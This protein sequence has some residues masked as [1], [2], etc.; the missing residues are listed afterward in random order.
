MG[1]RGAIP[2]HKHLIINEMSNV[3]CICNCTGGFDRPVAHQELNHESP[4]PS[5]AGDGPP[6]CGCIN[7]IHSPLSDIFLVYSER[8]SLASVSVQP[9][10]E[11]GL[12]LKVTK[13]QSF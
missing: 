11:R 8:R 9:V 10:L 7:L 5:A 1:E 2:I 4:H 12:T 13:L 6:G 3:L